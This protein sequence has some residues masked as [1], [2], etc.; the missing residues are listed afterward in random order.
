MQEQPIVR[1]VTCGSVD[2]GKSTL[3]GR[4]LVETNS[5][6]I[7]TLDSTKTSRRAGSLIPAGEID[8]S[9]LTD[10]LE[11]EREQG[12]TI[13]VAY[14]SMSL[15][16]GRRLI[17]A[18]APGHV[19]YTRNMA[20]AASRADV[21]LILVDAKRGIRTQTLR[22]L[23]ICQLMA[24]PRIIVAIN[25]LD[26][27]DYSQNVFD[28][29]VAELQP[30]VDRLGITEIAYVPVS[31]LAGDNVTVKTPATSWHGGR[32]LLDE[33]QLGPSDERAARKT[34]FG[35]QLVSRSDD[36]R[37]VSGTVT[38]SSLS[39]GDNVI[40]LP[41]EHTATV[42]RIVTFDGDSA[43]AEPGSAVTLV[44]EPDVDVTRGDVIERADDFTPPS[45]GF[46]ANMVW[47]AEDELVTN[48]SYYLINGSNTVVASVTAIRHRV[49]V[50]NGN[51]EAVRTLSMNEIAVVEIGTDSPIALS[52][53]YTDGREFGNFILVDRLTLATVAAGMVNFSLRRGT[54]VGAESF[55]VDKAQRA[56]LMGHR[57]QVVW[58]TGLPASGKSSLANEIEKRLNRSGVHSYILDGDNLRHGLNRNLGFTEEDRAENVRRIAEVARL[59][60]DAG[61]V[62]VVASVSPNRVD[63]DSARQLFDENEFVE[64][65][66]D[67]PLEVCNERDSKSLY[68]Q[69][70]NGEIPNLTGVG[71]SYQEPTNP[72]IVLDG[73][74][75]V[76]DNAAIVIT[77]IA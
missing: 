37:G 26:A 51:E 48:R 76:D 60:V 19:Q 12:I 21:G 69:A 27:V 65:W 36:F 39:V 44:L 42:A 35:V 29:L 61:L 49:N 4:L 33:I 74:Q 47:L 15:L 3:I 59:M 70:E 72:E 43:V 7:D 16:D 54:N 18:D 10:G 9:L 63:R 31:A 13:D 73:T 77:H 38:G 5:I 1:L 11:A 64:V 20:V 62:V 46:S 22:H 75:S 68:A 57:A 71:Q 67:T 41:R 66:L 17:I 32:T 56:K 52:S 14:R 40:V 45:T 30:T 24:V 58:I 25:K 6:P 53:Y 55:S 23:A 2:D 50:E 34:R 8:F 28:E